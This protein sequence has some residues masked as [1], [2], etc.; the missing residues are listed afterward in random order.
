MTKRDLLF[1]PDS[2]LRCQC[3]VVETF[4]SELKKTVDQMI[5]TM[6]VYGG[7]GLAAPQVGLLKNIVVID[8]SAGDDNSSLLAMVNPKIVSFNGV[9]TLSEEGCLSLP[10]VMLSVPR[11]PEVGVEYDDVVGNKCITQFTLGSAF[12]VQHELDHLMGLTLLDR[13]G[14]MAR[15]LALKNLTASGVVIT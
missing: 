8:P 1:Y 9:E 10:G 4:D 3:A 11:R 13:V 14:P 7:V 6:Y 15:R 2:T 12:I 5:E